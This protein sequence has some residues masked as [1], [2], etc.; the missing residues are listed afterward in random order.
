MLNQSHNSVE[1]TRQAI[2]KNLDAR[3]SPAERN[4]LGQFAT[5]NSL[6]VEIAAYLATLLRDEKFAVR[7]AEPSLGTGSFYSAILSVLGPGRMASSLG[8]E[9][10]PEVC[11]AASELWSEYGLRVICGD[12]TRVVANGPRLPRP[13]VILANPP[14]VRHHHFDREEKI[15]LQALAHE[16]AGIDVN[17]LAGLYVYF[18]ILATAWMEN[19]GYAAWLIPSEFMD[20]NYGRALKSYLADQLTLIRVHRFNPDDVQFGDALVSSAVLVFRKC[21][22]RPDHAVEFTFG[23]TFHKPKAS[24]LIPLPELRRARKWTVYPRHHGNDRCI[25]ADRDAPTLADFFKIRRG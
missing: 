19:D 12:F 14:Y 20:V 3:K 2:Q 25:S 21:T 11:Q 13:N 23:G 24:D 1:S 9:I 17:G 6:A 5:P 7:F 18:L 22:P 16:M 15:R 4:R 10:D 8:I